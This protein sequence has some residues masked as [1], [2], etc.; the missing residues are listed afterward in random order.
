[1]E[2][3]FFVF[4]QQLADLLNIRFDYLIFG[5]TGVLVLIVVL[6][7]IL[8]VE[9]IRF[10]YLENKQN[11]KRAGHVLPDENTTTNREKPAGIFTY[12]EANQLPNHLPEIY[13]LTGKFYRGYMDR[14][15]YRILVFENRVFRFNPESQRLKYLKHSDV[16]YDETE[17]FEEIMG[18]EVGTRFHARLEDFTLLYGGTALVEVYGEHPYLAPETSAPQV[19]IVKDK[20]DILEIEE[21]E[22]E[23][24]HLEQVAFWLAEND[25]GE[26]ILVDKIMKRFGSHRDIVN[27]FLSWGQEIKS[28]ERI[29]RETLK[30]ASY[31]QK[32]IK[33]RPQ[34]GVMPAVAS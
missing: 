2:Q 7:I 10:Q 33:L 1:M 15:G 13:S 6:L 22:I 34:P 27:S 20:E 24:L 14:L 31:T 3:Q 30:A 17:V 16:V 25:D 11:N 29:N 26:V 23:I 32:D 19:R 4:L 21:K 28:P 12:Y 9:N 8:L 18:A 5:L